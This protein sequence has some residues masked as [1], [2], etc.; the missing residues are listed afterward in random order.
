MRLPPLVSPVV[1]LTPGER[2]RTARQSRL[3]QLGEL[4]QRRLA[5]ARVCVLGAGGLG[6]PA[7]LYLAAAGVGTIGI[8]DDDVVEE[9]N[10]QRQIVHGL[11]DVGHPK[12]LSASR[13][14]AELSPE[15]TVIQHRVRLDRDN[16]VGILSGYDLVLDGTDNFETRYLADEICAVLG[17]PL[18]WAAVL[19]F[20]AQL[21][22]FW[23]DPPGGFDAVGVRLRD[24][25]PRQPETGDAPSCAEAGVLGALCGQVGSIMAAEAVKLVTGTGDPLLGRVLVIDALSARQTELPLRPMT[26]PGTARGRV[27]RADVPPMTSAHPAPAAPLTHRLTAS[28]LAERL[29]AKARGDDDFV[30]VDVREPEEHAESAIPGSRLVPLGTLLRAPSEVTLPRG[31]P[32]IVHCHRGSR[33]EQAA[34]ALSSAGFGDVVVLDGGIESWEKQS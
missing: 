10:L 16:A 8:V 12:V 22:V 4:G 25:F 9:S 31:V 19:Q 17:L 5:A 15:T 13:R 14:I 23:A 1:A 33:A 28:R 3:P 18:V 21:S 27:S 20:T 11:A 29:D 2:R 32:L 6:A 30:V 26:A 7:L 34:R 24:L